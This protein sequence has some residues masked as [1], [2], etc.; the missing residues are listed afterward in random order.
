M[1][2]AEH[3]NSTPKLFTKVPKI[4]TSLFLFLIIGLVHFE[5]LRVFK[6]QQIVK[7]SGLVEI[8]QKIS[9]RKNLK[10]ASIG[11]GLRQPFFNTDKI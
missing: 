2:T 9:L 1:R 8:P 3:A 7:K 6:F 11:N 10:F 5:L 4:E